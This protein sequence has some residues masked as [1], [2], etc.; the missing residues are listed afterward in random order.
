MAVIYL[1]ALINCKD[2]IRTRKDGQHDGHSRK[3]V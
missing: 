1:T 2:T 3:F